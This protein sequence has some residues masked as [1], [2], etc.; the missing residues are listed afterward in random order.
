MVHEVDAPSFPLIEAAG[1]A[2]EMGYEH[3][4]Q[5]RELIAR[6]L[7]WIDRIA[8]LPREVLFANALAYLAGA[9]AVSPALVDQVRGPA[10]GAGISLEEALLCQT[11]MPSVMSLTSYRN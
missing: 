9:Q 6:Y 2:D 1:S 7:L 3:G 10:R 4:R 11:P 5:A 8:R